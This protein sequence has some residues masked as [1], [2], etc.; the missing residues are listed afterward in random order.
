MGFCL[1]NNVAIA[2]QAARQQHGIERVA[3]LDWD[4]H[5]GN[6]TQDI[7]YEDPN[8][9]F[10]SIHQYP[11]YPGTG[12]WEQM[13]RGDGYGTTLNIPLRAG[14]GDSAYFHLFDE[15]V[16]PALT[17]FHPGLV[18]LSAGFDAHWRDPLASIQLTI[19]GYHQLA[20]WLRDAAAEL[21]AP[22]AVVLE[23]G[24]DLEAIAYGWHATL[25]GLL[26]RPLTVDPLGPAPD[27]PQPAI[28]L[29]VSRIRQSHPLL[30]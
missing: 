19:K 9:L 16:L 3:I 15:L 14:C 17:A 6:G 4:V 11:F 22:I 27:L 2:A 13:G 26:G 1:F 12:H 10:I 20:G 25:L 29:L 7:F 24:Y 23:G 8:V 18:L 30:R 21:E 5:H 28:D